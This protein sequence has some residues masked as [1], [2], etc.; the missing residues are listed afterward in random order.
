MPIIKFLVKI[1][2]KPVALIQ[3]QFLQK[4]LYVFYTVGS[5]LSSSLCDGFVESFLNHDIRHAS[6]LFIATG[7]NVS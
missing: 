2:H 3:N 1:V 7:P 6:F 5:F 4:L